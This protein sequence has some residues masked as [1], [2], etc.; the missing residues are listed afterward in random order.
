VE[1]HFAYIDQS[2]GAGI[3]FSHFP[4][5]FLHRKPLQAK[6]MHFQ[7]QEATAKCSRLKE[8]LG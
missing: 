7:T 2:A 8:E 1:T 4:V 5:Q 3:K 6:S